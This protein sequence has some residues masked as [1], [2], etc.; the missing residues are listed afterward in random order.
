MDTNR[1]KELIAQ[2]KLTKKP[3][4][5]FIIRSN[6]NNRCYIEGTQDLKGRMNGTKVRLEAGIHPN[7]E[8]QKEWQ[9]FGSENFTIEILDHLEYDKDESKTDYKA[10]LDF[11]KMI[12][13]EKLA[14]DSI[15]FYKKRLVNEGR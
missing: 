4:G 14:K 5:L 3:M 10:D 8:L 9:E 12:W 13:E 15:T 11:L 6:V 1:R 7:Q 2:Y